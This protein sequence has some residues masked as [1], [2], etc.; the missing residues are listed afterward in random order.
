[1]FL[2]HQKQAVINTEPR[3]QMDQLWFRTRYEVQRKPRARY[4]EVAG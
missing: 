3:L 1:M 4:T 2:V